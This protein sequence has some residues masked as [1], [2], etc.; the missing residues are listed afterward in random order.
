MGRQIVKRRY[1]TRGLSVPDPWAEAHGYHRV[2]A[3]RP[4]GLALRG[5]L[6]EPVCLLLRLGLV[7]VDGVA[8]P[9]IHASSRPRLAHKRGRVATQ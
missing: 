2:V 5:A 9:S 6:Q 3:T 7:A 1:A 8:V 4:N